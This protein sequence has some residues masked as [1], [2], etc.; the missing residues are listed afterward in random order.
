MRKSV[1]YTA[2]LSLSTSTVDTLLDPAP[3]LFESL[4]ER[5]MPKLRY[6][7]LRFPITQELAVHGRI[8]NGHYKM[9]HNGKLL[10]YYYRQVQ[11]TLNFGSSKITF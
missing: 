5:V 3:Q 11:L 4:T 8:E 10:I 9:H 1:N 6:T 7:I 2:G